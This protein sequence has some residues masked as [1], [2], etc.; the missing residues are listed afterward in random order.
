MAADRKKFYSIA[1]LLGHKTSGHNASTAT[2]SILY[3][4]GM[5]GL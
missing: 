2:I 4:G 5:L 1:K 3:I